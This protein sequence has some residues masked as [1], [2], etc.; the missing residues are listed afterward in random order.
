MWQQGSNNSLRDEHVPTEPEDSGPAGAA[1]SFEGLPGR[2]PSADTVDE[3]PRPDT[4]TRPAAYEV[5]PVDLGA[6]SRRRVLPPVEDVG[7]PGNIQMASSNGIAPAQR[8]SSISRV[9]PTQQQPPHDPLFTVI[10]RAASESASSED[11]ADTS[12]GAWQMGD[13]DDSSSPAAVGGSRRLSTPETDVAGADITKGAQS[14]ASC[15]ETAVSSHGIIQASGSSTD[16]LGMSNVVR[17]KK[18]LRSA[19]KTVG[20]LSR[21][22]K[23]SISG[24]S[25]VPAISSK[26]FVASK[27][28]QRAANK[29]TVTRAFQV[30]TELIGVF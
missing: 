22:R 7:A 27:V 20:F 8:R 6:A 28:L 15:S 14:G 17:T 10:G 2:L 18:S 21:I 23:T 12:A 13:S 1:M 4:Y 26:K 19:A 25:D 3:S 5:P 11:E 30:T 29:A 16:P 9:S 24:A